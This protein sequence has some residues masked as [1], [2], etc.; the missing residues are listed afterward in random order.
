MPQLAAAPATPVSDNFEVAGFRLRA[1]AESAELLAPVQSLM[2][3]FRVDSPNVSGW[4]AR[5]GRRD[6]AAT[7]AP[8]RGVRKIWSGE[9]APGLTALNYVGSGKRR[10]ELGDG[11][12]MDL[13]LSRRQAAVVLPEHCPAN[14]VGYFIT[15]MMC[16][17]L[18]AA[19]HGLLHA[20]CL[21]VSVRGQ[22][23]SVLIVAE[24]GMGKSTT[25]L[26]LAEAGWKLM[27]DDITLVCRAGLPLRAWGFPR[28]CHVRR[29]TLRLLPWLN[30][31][32]LAPTSIDGTF[33]LP[34][35]ALGHRACAPGSRP[36][37]PALIICLEPP[38]PDEHRFARLDRAA[39]LIRLS[40]E[41]VQPTEG[42]VDP[43]APRS[44]ATLAA[45][46][47]QAPACRLSVGPRLEQLAAFLSN[48]LGG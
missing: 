36:L 24:S 16:E 45:L 29:P 5:I 40:H 46:V 21:E 23:S 17:G 38:N 48:H 13:D 14:R 15:A 19:G 9:V 28:A 42:L 37:A 12:F 8:P 39:A 32:P 18:I 26:A 30:D 47:R 25:A 34:L 1:Q 2:G 33:D 22:A 4:R 11:S 43:V 27:G 31:L 41:N 7:T 6:R 20:A 10:L 3:A 35:D 44:F